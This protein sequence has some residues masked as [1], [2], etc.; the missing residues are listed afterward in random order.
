[1]LGHG[2]LPLPGFLTTCTRTANEV[3]WLLAAPVPGEERSGASTLN[4]QHCC[5]EGPC[6]PPCLKPISSLYSEKM[7]LYFLMKKIFAD[8][9]GSPVFC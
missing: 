7:L 5:S 3:I 9:T 6:F 8:Q 4:A 2:R 1:M